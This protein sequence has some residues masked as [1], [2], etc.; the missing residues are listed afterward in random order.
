MVSPFQTGNGIALESTIY[1]PPPGPD[2]W[3]LDSSPTAGKS[4]SVYLSNN[5]DF[6]TNPGC[7]WAVTAM[8]QG[9]I[10]LTTVA[11]GSDRR[12]LDS[13]GAA[14]RAYSVYLTNQTAGGG[15]HWLPTQLPL[16]RGYTFKCDTPSGSKRYLCADPNASK[17][18]SVFL[19]LEETPPSH[20][21]HWHILLTHCTGESVQSIIYAVYP[22]VTDQLL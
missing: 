17:E 20:A 5:K 7:Y 1:T 9:K 11:T 19:H 18:Q 16:Y 3:Y 21:T 15:S 13:S 14:S 8:T 22:S 4:T 6:K 12:Y 2:T 10:I